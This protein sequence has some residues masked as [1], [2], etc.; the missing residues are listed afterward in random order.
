ME[1][2]EIVRAAF[3]EAFPGED[4]GFVR[5]LPAT[6]PRFGDYQCNDALKLAKRL[7]QNPREVGAKVAAALKGND[8]FEKVEVA[9]PGFLNMTVSAGWVAAQLAA[10]AAPHPCTVIIKPNYKIYLFIGDKCI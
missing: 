7:K 8:V 9:G 10:L 2:S 1:L 3:A 4:F 6:D 5:V